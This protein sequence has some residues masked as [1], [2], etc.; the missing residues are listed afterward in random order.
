MNARPVIQGGSDRPDRKKSRLVDTEREQIGLL[1][2][3]GYSDLEAA[4]PYL[5][6]AALIGLIGSLAG[7]VL[8]G[9][10]GGLVTELFYKYVRF[11]H[12]ATQFS[13]TPGTAGSKRYPF[14]SPTILT[15]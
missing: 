11:T 3:F 15:S 2:A 8:G 13:W 10:L 9:W 4:A 6:L 5:K 7:G 1:K 14:A 12:F